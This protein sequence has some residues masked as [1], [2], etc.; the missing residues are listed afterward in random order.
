MHCLFV[1]ILFPDLHHRANWFIL[2]VRPAFPRISAVLFFWFSVQ[3]Q[4]A[5]RTF[6]ALDVGHLMGLDLDEYLRRWGY[7][8]LS[9]RKM[10]GPGEKHTSGLV[11][12]VLICT[13][14]VYGRIINLCKGWKN[15]RR[16]FRTRDFAV[17]A[18]PFAEVGSS[19]DR[20]E[21]F[22]PL[23]AFRLDINELVYNFDR[24]TLKIKWLW[25]STQRV[26]GLGTG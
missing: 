6:I 21:Y 1:F 9:I 18:S 19:A 5:V 22:Q 10:M 2:D 4:L 7:R 16:T 8:S 11:P 20:W 15:G 24:G 25:G 26:S 14:S 13:T 23:L 3:E 17:V 12:V